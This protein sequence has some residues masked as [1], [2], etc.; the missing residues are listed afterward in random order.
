MVVWVLKKND[1]NYGNRLLEKYASAG[2]SVPNLSQM[3]TSR[4][5]SLDCEGSVWNW[6]AKRHAG[7]RTG[8]GRGHSLGSSELKEVFFFHP[9]SSNSFILVYSLTKD[10][11]HFGALLGFGWVN[12]C[13]E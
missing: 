10:F 4:M 3:W 9:R 8:S 12:S 5:M 1:F 13:L 6:G 7:P 11:L 2:L